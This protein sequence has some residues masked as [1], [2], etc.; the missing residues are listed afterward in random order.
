M[1]SIQECSVTLW[2][3]FV[4][5]TAFWIELDCNDGLPCFSVYFCSSFIAILIEYIFVWAWNIPLTHIPLWQDTFVNYVF[6]I[7]FESDFS[8]WSSV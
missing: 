2:C 6:F 8:T 1:K 4:S 7:F 5:V 3:G